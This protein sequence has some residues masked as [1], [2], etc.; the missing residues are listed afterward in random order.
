M[1]HSDSLE[2]AYFLL[3]FC[4]IVTLTLN[5]SSS[6]LSAHVH[7]FCHGRHTCGKYE[8][9][10]YLVFLL[11]FIL[12]FSV[13]VRDK[14][15]NLNSTYTLQLDCEIAAFMKILNEIPLTFIDDIQ[16]CPEF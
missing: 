1:K 13:T 11:F 2:I 9:Q 7:I 14:D 10:Y 16:T 15:N 6:V 12:C 4:S 5:I 3:S 8:K